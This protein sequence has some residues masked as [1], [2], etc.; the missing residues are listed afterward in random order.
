MG[1]SKQL[2]VQVNV[3]RGPNGLSYAV[4]KLPEDE[5]LLVTMTYGRAE[6]G[7]GWFLKKI[8]T[9][10]AVIIERNPE[11]EE[12]IVSLK[13]VERC[14]LDHDGRSSVGTK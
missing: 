10:G 11:D 9:T 13:R 14:I 2:Q 3:M 5:H 1:K 7:S 12:S 8:L 6:G 4:D